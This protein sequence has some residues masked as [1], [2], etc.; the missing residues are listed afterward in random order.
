MGYIDEKDAAN[1]TIKA[2]NVHMCV[3]WST[4]VK[5][6]LGLASTGPDKSSRVT[7]A[8]PS[9]LLHGVTGVIGITKQA[10]KAWLSTP[11]G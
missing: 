9:A 7:K 6:V 1:T 5:G 4:D 2:E 10:E 3:Y 11:W 8:A